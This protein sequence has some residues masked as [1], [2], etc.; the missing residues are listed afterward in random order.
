MVKLFLRKA[1]KSIFIILNLFF[2]IGLLLSCYGSMLGNGQNWILGLVTLA[3]F[4]LLISNLIFIV[5]WFFAKPKIS[6][7]SILTILI[8]WIP[9]KNVFELRTKQPFDFNKAPN[10]IRIMSW[11]VEHFDIIEHKT[12]PEKKQEMINLINEFN[13]D[14]ACFQEM[15]AGDSASDAINYVP[16]FQHVL[17]MKDYH[18]SYNKK[19]D[20]DKKHRFGIMT[21]SK[22]PIINKVTIV[23]E[24]KSYNSIFQYIDIVKE[25]DTIRIFNIHLQSLRFN[26]SN[27]KYLNNFS[28]SDEKD[29]EESK[30]IL[31]KFKAGYLKRYIQ[32]N[33]ICD[34][35]HKSPYPIILCG[36]FND[37]PNSYAYLNIGK[38]MKNAFVEKGSGIG[39]TY[40]GIASTLRI[41][42]I[43][44]SKRFDVIQYVRTIKQLSDHFPIVSDL[45]IN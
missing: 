32:S 26:P 29:I 11:N 17:F 19:L 37:V 18:F 14:V 38:E 22:Y 6:L 8:C 23:G 7:L 1:A 27:R 41:D 42:N 35:I 40:D 25:K 10:N 4:H 45:K 9:L 33:R 24:P 20:F 15:V 3:S 44:A 12:H 43:F 16:D 34:E 21:F 36:D 5:F 30:S 2:S 39:N 28:I 31:K 13:P